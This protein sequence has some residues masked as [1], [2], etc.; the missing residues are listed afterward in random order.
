MAGG[1]DTALLRAAR[2]RGHAPAV[3]RAVARFSAL[4]EH[5]GVWLAAC[6]AGAALDR[7]RRDRFAR[8]GATVA[9]AY[10]ANQA[11]KVAVR[12]RRPRLD[13]LE[14]VVSTHSQ[15][16]YPSAH[17]STSF[18]GARALG[19]LWPRPAVYAMALALAA[20]RP[21]LGVH[22]PSDSLAGAA[23]GTAVAELAR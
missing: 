11:I 13:G 8:A 23:L 4:G 19:E 3:E 20:S 16:S 6:A 5:G 7:R 10:V 21:Y 17:A 14:P 18:A 2:T 22:Y 9:A 12:R 1:L 15:L